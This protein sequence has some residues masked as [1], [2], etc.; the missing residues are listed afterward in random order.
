VLRKWRKPLVVMTPKWLLRLPAATSSLAEFG[1]GTFRRVMPDALARPWRDVKQVLLCTGKIYY[2]LAQRRETS[3]RD[4]VAILRMEQ[5]YPLPMR[6]LQ[7][8]INEYA[9]GTPV[10]WVQEEPENM[11]AWR[12]LKIHWGDTLWGRHP[13]RGVMRPAS[14]SPATG[15]HHSHDLEQEAILAEAFGEEPSE[16][17]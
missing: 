10:A 5:L 4:D 15:S 14:A 17:S 9:P 8:T 3:N 1:P 13:F 7:Q 6:E 11:G 12:F 2:E 16:A